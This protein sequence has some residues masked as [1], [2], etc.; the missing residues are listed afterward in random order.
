MARYA[1][2]VNTTQRYIDV[3]KQFQ[4][5][6]KTVD[7]D[8]SL[9]AVYLRDAENVSLS[10]FGFI[11]KR[12]GTYE[13]FKMAINANEGKLQGYWEFLDKYIIVAFDGNIY[14]QLKSTPEATLNTF[15][16]W[17][18][19]Q[20]QRYPKVGELSYFVHQFNLVQT[21]DYTYLGT[22]VFQTEKE[23]GAVTQKNVIYIFTGTYP[24]FISE[25]AGALKAYFFSVTS[26]TNDEIVVVGHNFLENDFEQLY[27]DEIIK[28]GK[29]TSVSSVG[30]RGVATYPDLERPEKDLIS[31]DNFD[32][33]PKYPYSVDGKIDFNLGYK[34]ANILT[35]PF[36]IKDASTQYINT[37]ELQSVEM[38]DAAP[39]ATDIAFTAIDKETYIYDDFS[40]IS[41]DLS[42]NVFDPDGFEKKLLPT[43]VDG[44]GLGA[45]SDVIF[46][47][48]HFELNYGV[49]APNIATTTVSTEFPLQE[50]FKIKYKPLKQTIE[51]N[52]TDVQNRVGQSIGILLS[53]SGGGEIDFETHNESVRNLLNQLKF[54]NARGDFSFRT[55]VV[56]TG[57]QFIYRL[58]YDRVFENITYPNLIF[59]YIKDRDGSAGTHTVNGVTYTVQEV[60]PKMTYEIRNNNIYV[61]LTYETGYFIPLGFAG[62]AQ[63]VRLSTK[64]EYSNFLRYKNSDAGILRDSAGLLTVGVLQKAFPQTDAV[65]QSFSDIDGISETTVTIKP[66]NASG[67]VVAENA[68]KKLALN[69]ENLVF[70]SF[71]KQYRLTIPE[72]L[73][74][75]DITGYQFVLESN[76]INYDANT[77][78]FSKTFMSSVSND[79]LLDLKF[80]GTGVSEDERYQAWNYYNDYP[81]LKTLFSQDL[82]SSS[83]LSSLLYTI[84]PIDNAFE[85][86][87]Y[88]KVIGRDPIQISITKG[89]N[90]GTFDFKFNFVAKRQFFDSIGS[91]LILISEHPY[92]F[93]YP[94]ISVTQER[95]QDYPGL[96]TVPDLKLNPIWSCNNVIEH[97]G[98]LMVWGSTEMPHA[99]FYS[100]P[101]RPTY[102]PTYFYL[103][104]SN[105]DNDPLLAVTPF[106]NILVAQTEDQTWGIRGNSG[107]ITAPS[108]YIP[109]SINPTVGT[110]AP[111]SV[112]SVRN[113]LFFLAKTG[114]VALK[115]LYAADE[116][117][118]I[119]FVDRNIFNIVPQDKEAVGIQFDN[120]YWLNFPNFGITLR[121][122]ID[123]KA[124]VLDRFGSYTSQDGVYTLVKGAWYEYNGV[125]KWQNKNGKLEFISKPSRFFANDTLGIS[126]IGIDYSLPT[127]IG[128]NV[129]ARFETSF[130]NQNYPFHPK[131]YKETKLDFTVQNEY[132][133][134]VGQIYVMDTNE[135]IVNNSIHEITSNL[136]LIPNHR[137]EMQYYYD[138]ETNILDAGSNWAVYEDVVDGGADWFNITDTIVEGFY[139]VI[140]DSVLVND[141]VI[142]FDVVDGNTVQFV[143]PNDIGDGLP[144]RLT[145][146]FENYTLGS[147]LTNVTYDE[148]FKFKAWVI[149][150]NTTL[151]IDNTLDS[152]E[153]ALVEETVNKGTKM[154]SWTFGVSDFGNKVTVVK[155]MKLA[156]KGY[157]AKIYVEDESKTKW[158]LESMGITYKMK[159]ARSR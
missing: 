104:F 5:G 83:N 48:T 1:Y 135:D 139:F 129:L 82:I 154:G 63:Y 92:S 62:T 4:G 47:L 111:K 121:W 31:V 142:P 116:Q 122:Y 119:E 2:D 138:Y 146:H 91:Q 59:S 88:K 100:F 153:E 40:N 117:Y 28:S 45:E 67:N 43:G 39:G 30:V 131:N 148:D 78:T 36:E 64:N 11:E 77:T 18:V 32:Y 127:D 101:D 84:G 61:S 13:N 149:S 151:N 124:W 155:T 79:V 159:R 141:I 20:G 26:P 86:L 68:W 96:E 87:N 14:W 80:F 60:N 73:L 71:S 102:F 81:N 89:L 6:L 136:G 51:L 97:F 42:L 25:E 114:V 113:H 145:G 52:A 46:P 53:R 109:F 85:S 54:T 95:Y 106:M 143:L 132:N 58:W 156:G 99:L 98:K 66:I 7:T 29:T 12:Y 152:Y 17:F 21:G 65:Q 94:N 49:L 147:D 9:G 90:A 93:V 76:I 157:N 27:Y 22:P 115:S 34:Y 140:I 108:P 75:V 150:E 125:F 56:N 24:I 120:Q 10:E 110:I 158:T 72:G 134:N 105:N 118:N 8:D 107:I 23:M 44:D 55:Q 126:K 19:P 123:K 112:R 37:I 3:H 130:L 70:D 50:L 41:N 33:A 128:G 133:K 103:D 137:Y 69:T 16:N 57:Q 38:R 74:A 15:N 35:R 144:F